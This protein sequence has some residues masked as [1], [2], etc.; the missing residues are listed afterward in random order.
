MFPWFK[1]QK[2]IEFVDVSRNA[3]QSFPVNLAKNLPV[4]GRDAR[5][6]KYGVNNFAHC[7]GMIDYANM[8][9]IIPAWIDIHIKANKAGVVS[10]IGSSKRG[11]RGFHLPRKMDATLVEGMLTPEDDIPL[12]VLHIGAPWNIFVSKNISAIILPASYHSSIHEDLHIWPG[13]VDYKN[14][15]TANL[16]CTPKRECEIHIKAGEPLLQVIPFLNSDLVGGYG[17]GTEEQVDRANN[18]ITTGDSQ[19]YRKFLSVKKLFKL[20]PPE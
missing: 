16:I 6:E 19:F 11:S 2:D 20:D 1:K 5:I 12:T 14:F 7:P 13:V 8:G 18:T 9:Y 4:L 17:P 3:Y 10:T 15:T